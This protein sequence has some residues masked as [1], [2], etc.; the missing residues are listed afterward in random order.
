VT[1]IREPTVQLVGLT[2][3]L[4]PGDV[5]WTTDT[6]LDSHQLIEF[7]GRMCY[8][9]WHNP[10][11]R[12][13]AEYIGNM[14]DHGHL[15]VIEHGIASFAIKGVSRSLTHEL[16]R[17]RHFSYSQ[18]SQRYVSSRD[19]NFVEP[20]TIAEEPEAHQ[21]FTELC[22]QARKTYRRLSTILQ[23]KYADVPDRTLRRKLARQAA[24]SVLPNA[25]ETQLV[26]T[27]NFRAWRHFI[28][29]RASEHADIEIRKLAILILRCLQPAAPA[30]FG[31]YEIRT[32]DD[33]TEAAETEHAFE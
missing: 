23:K 10:A 30:I 19:A 11:G 14:L 22:E 24:R 32:L 13:N 27:G 15:S 28:R 16:V 26:M 20:Q 29:M 17:H 25:T 21:L 1:F 3:F 4:N 2:R 33:G 18:L 12:T 7:S 5:D 31:D 9:S 8:Q 6:T